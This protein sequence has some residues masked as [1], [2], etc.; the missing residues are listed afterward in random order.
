MKP[1]NLAV[2]ILLFLTN[3]VH[4][5]TLSTNCLSLREF[6]DKKVVSVHVDPKA[7][8]DAEAKYPHELNEVEAEHF[9]SLKKTWA[10]A[11]AKYAASYKGNQQEKAKVYELLAEEV[12]NR[13]QELLPITKPPPPPIPGKKSIPYPSVWKSYKHVLPGGTIV[14]IGPAANFIEFHPDKF[15]SEV[16]GGMIYLKTIIAR[17]ARVWNEDWVNVAPYKQSD[18]GRDIPE[19]GPFERRYLLFP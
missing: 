10:V 13:T 17:K 14:F 16:W 19:D 15:G 3:E 9:N 11:A 1:K 18:E 2:F 7:V 6:A 5:T 8:L 4:A 12:S